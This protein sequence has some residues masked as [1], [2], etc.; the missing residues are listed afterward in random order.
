MKQ[1]SYIIIT[2]CLLLTSCDLERMPYSGYTDE[3]IA[4]DPAA[5]DLMLQ[6]CYGQLKSMID[7]NHRFGEYPGD[8]LLKDKSSTDAFMQY[9][10]YLHNPN[11]AGRANTVWN[12]SYKIIAQTSELM[13]IVDESTATAEV[14]HQLGEAYYLRGLSYFF[15]CRIFGRPYYQSP[16]T[17]L[18]LPI[19]NGK[20]EDVLADNLTLPDRATVKQTYAQAIADLRKA[21]SLMTINKSSI[22]VTKQAAQAMLSRV[23]LYMSGTY[24]NPN[25]TYADSAI[26]YA[27]QVIGSNR[28]EMLS[29]ANFMNYNTTIPENNRETIFAVKRT[30]AD[31]SGEYGS[32]IGSLYCKAGG[33]GWGEIYASAK[34]MDRL[35]KTG[36]D[37]TRVFGTTAADARG[38]FIRPVYS[39]G[40]AAIDVFRVIVDVYNTD[41]VLANFTYMQFPIDTVAPGVYSV[42]ES[43]TNYPLT[44]VGDRYTFNYRPANA[45]AAVTYVG[46]IDKHIGLSSGFPMFYI[47]KCSMEGNFAQLHPP[48]ISR[49]AE[50]YLNLAEAYA[51]KDDYANALININVVRDRAVVGNPVLSTDMDTR[52]KAANVIDN[53]RALELAFEA[54]RGYDVY[55]IGRAMERRYP[56]FMRDQGG[57]NNNLKNIPAD[58]SAAI[59]VLSTTSINAYSVY[60]TL[61]QNPVTT[62]PAAD[63]TPYTEFIPY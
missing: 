49:L 2:A 14:K 48:I 16:E 22:F 54:H 46:D 29:R 47:W 55:R 38:S 53:E 24:E 30:D 40:A 5:L 39:T 60:G 23:Y 25:I 41:G 13:K 56:G 20:P 61:T 51:K 43:G 10:D 6:G 44:K 7:N 19:V 18:G 50:M 17:N 59:Q 45:P 4:Q 58:H 52:A 42:S 11:N 3:Q 9:I 27:N 12:A 57:S 1:L 15:L 21:E 35:R 8:N 62:L 34:Y 36:G 28:Y 32:N 26:H 37:E 33:K 63:Y 31:A